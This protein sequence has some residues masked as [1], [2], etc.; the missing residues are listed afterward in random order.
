M[1]DDKGQCGYLVDEDAVFIWILLL[2]SMTAIASSLDVTCTSSTPWMSMDS[3]TSFRIY[4]N[5]VNHAI[6]MHIH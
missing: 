5:M 4:M 2:R 1:I 3:W 6:S